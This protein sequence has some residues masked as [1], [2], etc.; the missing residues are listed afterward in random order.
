MTATASATISLGPELC[1]AGRA[2]F[3]V[4]PRPAI[5]A[6]DVSATLEA[7]LQRTESAPAVRTAARFDQLRGQLTWPQSHCWALGGFFRPQREQVIAMFL[8]D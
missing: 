1:A 8:L 6:H 7:A 5:D 4:D 3:R 2:M